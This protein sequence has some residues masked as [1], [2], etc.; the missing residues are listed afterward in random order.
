MKKRL[1]SALLV[2]VMMFSLAIPAFAAKPNTMEPDRQEYFKAQLRDIIAGQ[3]NGSVGELINTV[4]GAANGIIGSDTIKDMIKGVVNGMF[5]IPGMISGGTLGDLLGDL[6]GT[7]I[8]GSLGFDLPDSININDIIN[9]VVN[10]EIVTNILNSEFLAT[11][12][13]RVIDGLIDTI[14]I[15]NVVSVLTDSMIN[16]F[17]NDTTEKIWNNG[18]PS[19]SVFFGAQLGHWHTTNDAWN[20]TPIGVTV[21]VD[22]LAFIGKVGAAALNGD[23]DG[24]FDIGSIDFMALL[25]GTDVILDIVLNAVV[26]TATEYYEQFKADLIAKVEAEIQK[27]KDRL[28]LEIKQALCEILNKILPVVV[29]VTDTYEEIKAKIENYID[30][31]NDTKEKVEDTIKKLEALKEKLEN[32]DWAKYKSEAIDC[33]KKLLDCLCS[34]HCD[35]PVTP[36]DHNLQEEIV[37]EATCTAEGSLRIYCSLCDFEEFTAIEKI[38]HF[39][40][41]YDKS[42]ST[43]IQEGYFRRYCD[44]CGEMYID[45]VIPAMEHYLEQFSQAP[46]CTE[47]GFDK[48]ICTRDGCGHIESEEILPALGHTPGEPVIVPATL[49]NPGSITIFCTVCG[50]EISSEV[51]P[52]LVQEI[53]IKFPGVEDVTV[54]FYSPNGWFDIGVYDDEVTFEMPAD[55]LTYNG[56]YAVQ[57]IKGG[58]SYQV[59]NI[60]ITGELIDIDVPVQPITVTGITSACTLAIVQANWVYGDT[61][62]AIGEDTEFNVFDNDGT[63][64]IRIGRTGYSYAVI[65]G[66]SAGDIVDISEYFYDITVPEGVS[67]VGIA[68]ANWVDTTVTDGK[69]TLMKN[70]GDAKL[71]FNYDGK[72]YVIDFVL[73]GTNPF[74]SIYIMNFPGIEGVT[75]QYY[76]N[77]VWSSVPGT[78]DNSGYFFMPGVITSVRAAKGGMTYQ[79]DGVNK[80]TSKIFDVPVGTITIT[81]IISACEL[82]I[83]GS[84]WVYHNL[85]TTIGEDKSFNVFN[86]VQGNKEY[87]LRISKAGH[88]NAIGIMVKI[89]TEFDISEYFYDVAV[90]EGF[91]GVKIS[92]ANW[93][94]NPANEGD[95]ITFLKNYTEAIL[96]CTYNGETLSKTFLL[97]GTNPFDSLI[98]KPVEYANI[99]ALIKTINESLD[100]NYKLYKKDSYKKL[101]DSIETALILV[102]KHLDGSELLLIDQQDAVDN[103]EN[104]IKSAEKSLKKAGI[105]EAIFNY[106]TQVNRLRS[107]IDTILDKVAG[108]SSLSVTATVANLVVT[109]TVT[110]IVK[111]TWADTG[112]SINY[113]DTFTLK[114]GTNTYTVNGFK[115]ELTVSNGKVIS[116]VVLP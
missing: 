78:F 31:Y 74:D 61:V 68:N 33:I 102:E 113:R 5:D 60:T 91:T 98:V 27:I 67:D 22:V 26:E 17:I 49:E 35:D 115:V 20:T 80:L 11:V 94:V 116:A 86:N 58:M 114:N 4:T 104:A 14:D 32:M 107:R 34:K 111:E 53:Y 56:Y 50:E 69:I 8:S 90:P 29:E 70:N 71:Y 83:V 28:E 18:N 45:D 96:S 64:E 2:L 84:D 57:A 85:P 36:C 16:D 1:I 55:A 15:T 109:K 42:D 93:I 65:T 21:G 79:I 24:I 100:N 19:S 12:I 112:K 63:Y 9:Q 7:A 87:E 43:C 25:P 92:N 99:D 73:D 47:D 52:V 103:A 110:I 101:L 66:V 13:D 108:E 51:I 23:F 75:I 106:A 62:T 97:D 76:M 72:A 41:T 38:A 40:E 30:L 77:G 88:K 6:I 37:L 81:G 105:L 54:R 95:T 59:S 89:D 44:T 82:S 10:N 48:W 39:T 46:D 3:V